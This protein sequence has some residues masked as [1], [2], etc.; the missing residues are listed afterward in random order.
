M[1]DMNRPLLAG[2]AES[3]EPTS[4]LLLRQAQRLGQD[5]Q[6]HQPLTGDHTEADFTPLAVTNSLFAC[7]LGGL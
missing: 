3:G 2:D 1:S 6:P 4:A 5:A 7:A